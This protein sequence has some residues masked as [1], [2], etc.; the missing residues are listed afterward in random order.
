MIGMRRIAALVLV[1]LVLGSGPASAQGW[2]VEVSSSEM[3]IFYGT[4]GNYAEMM[5]MDLTSSYYR[6]NTGPG[7]G[8]G[9][10]V[11]LWPSYWSNNQLYQG[12]PVATENWSKAGSDLVLY[13]TGTV[14]GLT[15]SAKMQ[16]SPPVGKSFSVTVWESNTGN[17]TID[18]RPN[19]AFKPVMLSSMNEGPTSWDSYNVLTSAGLNWYPSSGWINKGPSVTGF[20]VTGGNSSWK[21]NAP[22]MT[23]TM[24][25][26]RPVTGWV[27]PSTDP[28]DDNVGVW[29]AS[30]S[31]A[32]QRS[33]RYT[34]VATSN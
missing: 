24:D 25:S 15:C 5:A 30:P 3:E 28:N 32:I 13:V 33:Y 6:L 29:A 12:G 11:I 1:L 8:W 16:L 34:V 22:T 31:M 2:S 7:C 21:T 18:P 14:G 27:T 26:A 23:V 20:Q 9:T 17:V 10:S 19:E 4:R